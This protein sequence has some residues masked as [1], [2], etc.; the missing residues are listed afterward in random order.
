[1]DRLPGGYPQGASLAL[2]GER[3]PL[4]EPNGDGP[5]PELAD[6]LWSLFAPYVCAAAAGGLDPGIRLPDEAPSRTPA[7]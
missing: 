5:R 3:E 4:C 6:E 2:S 7:A 1:M